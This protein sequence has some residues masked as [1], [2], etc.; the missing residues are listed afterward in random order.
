MKIA[1]RG[2]TLVVGSRVYCALAHAG[3]GTV[4]AIHGDQSPESVSAPVGFVS[5]GGSAE[6]DV[7][8]DNGHVSL[9][10]P[11]AIVRG[12]QWRIDG[13]V[14]SSEQIEAAKAHAVDVGVR[15]REQRDAANEAHEQSVA[16][17]QADPTHAALSQG[18]DYSGR[19]AGAN[20][21][22]ELAKAF[23]RARFHVRKFRHGS[24]TVSWVDGP[25]AAQVEAITGRHLDGHFDSMADCYRHVPNP[26]AEVFGGARFITTSRTPSPALVARA[27]D[28][29]FTTY[30]SSLIGTRRPNPEDVKTGHTWA[31]EVPGTN[32]NL[33]E[34]IY[35]TAATLEGE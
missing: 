33:Q 32:A 25:T 18:D 2:S 14:F 31:T 17:L 6:F 35:T 19:L 26:W 24:L 28:R 20:I 4:V 8:F 16:A 15:L 9:S 13:E 29:V 11:E 3:N 27:I 7:V 21:R 5:A 22:R 12:A 30:A 10:V 23:P 1:N 34:L